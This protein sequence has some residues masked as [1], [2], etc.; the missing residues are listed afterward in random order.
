MTNKPAQRSQQ[1]GFGCRRNTLVRD[2]GIGDVVWV[3]SEAQKETQGAVRPY[4]VYGMAATSQQSANLQSQALGTSQQAATRL[5]EREREVLEVLWA[6]GSATVQQVADS[7]KT[8]LAYTTVMTT[9]DR[10]YKKGLLQRRKHDRAFVYRPM[11]SKN[12]LERGRAS[13][14]VHR[15]FSG[16]AI[17][18]DAAL[19]CLVE[20]VQSYDTG[21]LQ[22][23]EDKVRAAKQQH[24]TAI[25]KGDKL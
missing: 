9:L 13:E 25:G 11:L 21:L 23:L 2:Q 3:Q 22:R 18:Q 1:R 6:A 20:A 12:D 8:A 19:S 14:M 24:A 7:L 5:G 10:L 16:S 4:S 15:L 17:N